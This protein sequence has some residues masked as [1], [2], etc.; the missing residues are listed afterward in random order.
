MYEKPHLCLHGCRQIASA[1]MYVNRVAHGCA[2]AIKTFS[3]RCDKSIH[4]TQIRPQRVRVHWEVSKKRPRPKGKTLST[5]FWQLPTWMWVDRVAHG[6]T[7]AIKTFSPRCD[8][9]I[10]ETQIRFQRVRVHWEVSKKKPRP[11]GRGFFV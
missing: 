6:C 9:S 7:R 4:E 3:P 11:K 1:W 5:D 2:G 10:H 8:K